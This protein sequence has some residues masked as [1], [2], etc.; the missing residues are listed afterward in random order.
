MTRTTRGADI[1]CWLPCFS[2][3]DQK[4]FIPEMKRNELLIPISE[5]NY[6]NYSHFFQKKAACGSFAEQIPAFCVKLNL[7]WAT[8]VT[9]GWL[10]IV[11]VVNK[12][13]QNPFSDVLA[14]RASVLMSWLCV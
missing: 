14:L 4:I 6:S 3:D 9:F 11:S 8:N 2:K 13:L 10:I 1:E 5:H 12:N 7:I